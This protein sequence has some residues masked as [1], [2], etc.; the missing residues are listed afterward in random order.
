MST[1]ILNNYYTFAGYSTIT[2]PMLT[3]KES[4]SKTLLCTCQE[5]TSGPE[6]DTAGK[7]GLTAGRDC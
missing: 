4:R 7:K 6:M 1:K 2:P 3:R 5:V